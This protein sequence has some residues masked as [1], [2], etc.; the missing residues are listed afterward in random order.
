MFDIDWMAGMSAGVFTLQNSDVKQVMTELEKVIGDKNLS[1][2]TGILKIV[3]IE[4]MNALLVITPQPAYLEEVKKWIGRLDK[5]GG[6]DGPQFYVYNL[7]NTRAERLAPLLQQAFTGRASQ[8]TGPAAPTLAP[9]TPAGTIVNPPGVPA[10]ARGNGDRARRAGGRGRRGQPG[11]RRARAA[12]RASC[13]TCRW[14][15]TRTTTRC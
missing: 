5:G 15:P 8:P 9:G 12:A 2:L 6:G 1:P 10:A 4:R 13:A 14:S 3:P 11:A 7:Q